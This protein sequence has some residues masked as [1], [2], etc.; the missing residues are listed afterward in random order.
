[1]KTT[2]NVLFALLLLGVSAGAASAPASVGAEVA[3]RG[4]ASVDLGFFY[5]NLVGPGN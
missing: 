2:R 4:H 1:M 5:D 3:S